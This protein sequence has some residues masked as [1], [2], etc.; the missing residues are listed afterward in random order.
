MKEKLAASRP[1]SVQTDTEVGQGRGRGQRLGHTH[2]GVSPRLIL[3]PITVRWAR[4]QIDHGLIR[5]EEIIKPK[6]QGGS[7]FIT[8]LGK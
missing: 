4:H 6:Q 5:R 2:P 7:V 3:P 8:D 1:L